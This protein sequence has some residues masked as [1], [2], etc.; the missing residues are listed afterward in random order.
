MCQTW[1]NMNMQINLKGYNCQFDKEKN[2]FK[3]WI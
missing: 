3:N 2:I 1:R